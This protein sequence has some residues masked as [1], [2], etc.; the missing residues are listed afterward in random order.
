[1]GK[2]TRN[3]ILIG[4]LLLGG[5]RLVLWVVAQQQAEILA[6]RLEPWVGLRYGSVD[7][8][9]DGRLRLHKV[10]FAPKMAKLPLP[11]HADSLS[12][13]SNGIFELLRRALTRE[14]LPPEALEL[15]LDAPTW[16]AT[17]LLSEARAAGWFG[18]R[19][20]VP[21]EALG[22]GA[23]AH[24]GE[25]D[26]SHMG[27][28][29]GTQRL[30]LAYR[31]EHT[32]RTLALDARAESLPFLN[33]R[34]HAELT[35]LDVD[36]LGEAKARAMIRLHSIA[37]D[38]SDLG[39]LVH[40]NH[41]CA[42][43]LGASVEQ[44]AEHHLT[45][46]AALLR[47]HGIE[48]APATLALYR[49]F[50]TRGGE[51]NLLA[52]PNPAVMPADYFHIERGDV[53]RHLN[54]TMRHDRAPPIMLKLGFLSP[55]LR[56]EVPTESVAE[57]PT[58]EVIEPPPPAVV[59]AGPTSTDPSASIDAKKLS[60]SVPVTESATVSTSVSVER[61]IPIEPPPPQP[62][63]ELTYEIVPIDSLP[64]RIGQRVV[65]ITENGKALSGIVIATDDL[66]VTL[67]VR[68]ETGSAELSLPRL[69]L[70]EVRRLRAGSG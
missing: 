19:S 11:L 1:M 47:D 32:T 46:I 41:F 12:L 37:I 67:R 69:R 2:L 16:P 18:A 5:T 45:E 21:F 4:L 22:C 26:F 38:I 30:H 52:L 10:E 53:L 29:P 17:G 61:E 58:A 8:G 28:S 51:L 24:F 40:R 25:A 54:L 49:D 33:V 56:N 9:F 60:G 6:A 64:H 34:A 48:A 55:Q 42:Q 3:I 66:T 57:I 27:L 23:L 70:R 14:T 20:W 39:Y 44:F 68:R 63:D 31:Y 35:G 62:E 7:A 59:E 65:L 15:E 50:A 43:Q 36:H 13:R